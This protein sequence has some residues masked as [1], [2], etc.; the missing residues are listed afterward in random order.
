MILCVV[1]NQ[2]QSD[3]SCRDDVDCAIAP[4]Q[5]TLNATIRTQLFKGNLREKCY[6]SQMSDLGSLKYLKSEKHENKPQWDT[7]IGSTHRSATASCLV[8]FGVGREM[9]SRPAETVWV[10]TRSSRHRPCGVP[11]R[12]GSC[13]LSKPKPSAH[14]LPNNI[15]PAP[16]ACAPSAPSERR[17]VIIMM[18]I[19]IMLIIIITC[20]LP[21]SHLTR[22]PKI[23][24]EFE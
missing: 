11:Q 8:Y 6:S 4:A 10:S 1:L 15:H 13:T 3:G 14:H 17:V 19:I 21:R 20:P 7:I 9:S 16:A 12:A 24:V 23:I 5:R 22:L 18:I 2:E